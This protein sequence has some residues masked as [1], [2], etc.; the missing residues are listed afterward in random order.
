MKKTIFIILLLSLLL[1][2]SGAVY[3]QMQ[4]QARIDSLLTALNN[5]DAAQT[6]SA[7]RTEMTD[8]GKVNLLNDLS[9]TLTGI[10]PDE[11]LKYGNQALALSEKLNWKKGI[12]ASYRCI[13]LTYW[14][15]SDNIKALEYHRKALKINEE[16]GD[17]SAEARNY[18]NIGVVYIRTSE[19]PKAQE[20]LLKSLKMYEDLKDTNGMSLNY[21]NLGNV[22]AMTSNPEKA[23]EY[24]MKS[25]KLGEET[26][27]KTTGEVYVNIGSVYGMMSNSAKA[28]EYYRK[29]L[30]FGE[31]NGDK[32]TIAI[33]LGNIGFLYSNTGEYA[34]SLEYQHK[35]LQL[36]KEIASPYGMANAYSNIGHVYYKIGSG[37]S[38]ALLDK[39]FAG[40][41][42]AALKQ[43]KR[44]DDSALTILLQIKEMAN[45]STLYKQISD[46]QVAMGNDK[47]ALESYKNYADYKDS[48]FNTEKNK[49]LTQTAMQYEFDKKEA[50]I[51]AE[52]EKKDIR[53]KNIRNSIVAG[54]AGAL[55]F[56]AVVYRQRNKISKE[57][58]ISENLR[59]QSDK[60]LHNILPAEVADELKDKGYAEAKQ[61]DEV[62][63]LFTDFV[64]FTQAAEKLSPQTLVQELHECFTAFD[65]II[66]RN[67]LEKIKTIGD[68]YLAVCGLP[69]ADNHHAQKTI[70]VALE[71]RDFMTA[72]APLSFGEGLG[73]RLGIHSGSVVAGIVGVKKFAYDIWGDTVNTAA[74]ME[75]S[76]ETGKV[77]ISETTREL[78]KDDFECTYRGEIEAKNKGKMRMYFVE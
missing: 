48:V 43:S 25:L 41:K 6:R 47:A 23:L 72:R 8:T 17:K 36:Q 44:Y 64:N 10:N 74:R 27:D 52:Q 32:A 49:K 3:A 78:V 65:N 57:K 39:L 67:G 13:G 16:I 54:L 77:N 58:K 28:L 70:Q 21:V 19:Y 56:L 4:G 50:T 51:K 46:I 76:G 22:Y 40:D 71:I 24:Y 11:G 66:E 15:K 73:V 60:L 63:V 61:F 34:L 12:A 42:M 62:S 53:Q 45:L 29:S 5:Y 14:S 18:A 30:K 26:G 38:K 9:F 20:N 69:V 75:Q 33:A 59:T 7:N 1:G 2:K 55:L 37:S 31:E 35:T 68:A